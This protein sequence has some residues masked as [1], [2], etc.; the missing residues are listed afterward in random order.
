MK[1]YK[2]IIVNQSKSQ[3]KSVLTAKSPTTNIRPVKKA[4]CCLKGKR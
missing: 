1:Q 4:G 3:K 2:P